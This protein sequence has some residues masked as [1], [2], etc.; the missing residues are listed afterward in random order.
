MVFYA[1]QPGRNV[2]QP[3]CNWGCAFGVCRNKGKRSPTQTGRRW[4]QWKA[5][6]AQS[7]C[8]GTSA[9]LGQPGCQKG[10]V[11]CPWGPGRHHGGGFRRSYAARANPSQSRGPPSTSQQKSQ[12][13]VQCGQ[14]F[15]P[16]TKPQETATRRWPCCGPGVHP[17]AAGQPKTASILN[18]PPASWRSPSP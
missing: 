13:S 16:H 15:E 17:S 14:G 10:T 9:S 3:V 1:T 5:P 11:A 4:R 2:T 12:W 18:H 6:A 7:Q 8:G